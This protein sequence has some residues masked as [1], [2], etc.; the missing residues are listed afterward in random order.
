MCHVEIYEEVCNGL[1]ITAQEQIVDFIRFLW[2][3]EERVG[4]EGYEDGTAR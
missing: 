3:G 4:W 2:R 1:V